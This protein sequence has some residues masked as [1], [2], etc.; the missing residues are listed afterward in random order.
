MLLVT[1][2]LAF[3]WI[4]GCW[5]SPKFVTD[6]NDLLWTAEFPGGSLCLMRLIAVLYR[7]VN[8]SFQHQPI[9]FLCVVDARASFCPNLMDIQNPVAKR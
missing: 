8:K 9:G 3:D 1:V 6:I 2:A 4:C 7:I 5:H